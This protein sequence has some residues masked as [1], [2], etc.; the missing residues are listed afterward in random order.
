M[1]E[2]RVSLNCSVAMP[3]NDIAS[4]GGVRRGVD[5]LTPGLDAVYGTRA[6]DATI[7]PTVPRPSSAVGNQTR[8]STLRH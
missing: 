4:V 3:S 2:H 8:P 7:S 1:A 5:A 6:D